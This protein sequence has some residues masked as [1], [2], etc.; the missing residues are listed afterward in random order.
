MLH[1]LCARAAP[2]LPPAG[3]PD[4]RSRGAP[5]RRRARGSS[6]SHCR[7]YRCRCCRVN[8]R[9]YCL[10]TGRYAMSLFCSFVLF[11]HWGKSKT[12]FWK[13]TSLKVPPMNCDSFFYRMIPHT[14]LR[15]FSRVSYWVQRA[16][17]RTVLEQANFLCYMQCVHP[18][19]MSTTNTLVVVFFYFD[20]TIVPPQ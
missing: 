5:R 19:N 11:A 1:R 6:G 17:V 7:A 9:E 12:F 13:R 2:P 4:Q 20:E 16:A 10:A 8:G 3:R 18:A 15:S 14:A